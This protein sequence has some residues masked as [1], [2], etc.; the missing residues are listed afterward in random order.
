L[1]F[2]T[3]I[4][5]S[6]PEGLSQHY[7]YRSL[8]VSLTFE[9]PQEDVRRDVLNQVGVAEGLGQSWEETG[10][11]LRKSGV[12]PLSCFRCGKALLGLTLWSNTWHV[13]KFGSNTLPSTLPNARYGGLLDGRW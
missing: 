13:L 10:I 12:M 8:G 5:A 3:L 4:Q 1:Q 2:I 7:L 9:P 11:W 6:P